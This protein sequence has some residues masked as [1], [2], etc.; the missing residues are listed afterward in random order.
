MIFLHRQNKFNDSKNFYDNVDGVEVDIRS[1]INGLV[2]DHDRLHHNLNHYPLFD[3]EIEKFC[4]IRKSIIFNIKESG[5]EEEIIDRMKDKDIEWYFLDSQI[6]DILRLSKQ[7]PEISHKFII[8]VSDVETMNEEFVRKIQPSFI[9]L[10]FSS[11]DNYSSDEYVYLLFDTIEQV[12]TMCQKTN[13][14]LV[15]PELYS[16]DYIDIAK[17]ISNIFR[18]EFNSIS[19]CTKFPELYRKS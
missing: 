9:W 15:S 6:P 4:L 8:R 5:V 7:Y 3:E 13:I 11:F 18:K 2:L 16:L 10:D 1:S 19:V 14:I 17:Y 12:N